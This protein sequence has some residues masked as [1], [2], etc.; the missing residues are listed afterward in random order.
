MRVKQEINM[1][2]TRMLKIFLLVDTPVA[3]SSVPG[4]LFLKKRSVRRAI[5]HHPVNIITRVMI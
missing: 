3:S 4:W 5:D 2:I 1:T